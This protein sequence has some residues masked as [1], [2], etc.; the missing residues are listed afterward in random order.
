MRNT[1]VFSK[2]KR[3]WLAHHGMFGKEIARI[4]ISQFQ[5][6]KILYRE[7]MIIDISAEFT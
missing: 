4:S 2:H 3:D 7:P 5:V 1:R 6:F